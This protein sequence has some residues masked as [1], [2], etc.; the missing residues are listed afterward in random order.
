M[1]AGPREQLRKALVSR[2]AIFQSTDVVGED[3]TQSVGDT[4]KLK[5]NLTIALRKLD[6][7][8]ALA[9]LSAHTL[10]SPFDARWD[11]WLSS[12]QLHTL[13]AAVLEAIQQAWIEEAE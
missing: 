10:T 8:R 11:D 4:P 9:E 1:T 2:G 12:T 3:G 6:V 7:V 5:Q 13:G